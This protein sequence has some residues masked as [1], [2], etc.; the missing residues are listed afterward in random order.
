MKDA[1]K[2]AIQTGYGLGLLS[3]E[4]G[5]KIAG[6]VRKEL[7]LNDEEAKKLA[8]ELVRS[9]K[10][11]SEEVIKSTSRH[12]EKG[13]LQRRLKQKISSLRPQKNKKKKGVFHHVK[14][15]WK[16]K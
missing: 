7:N 5:K 8:T 3:I 9:S 15:A 4:Q 1:V 12:F 2:K 10:K 6:Q 11:V 16:K 13:V 14:K